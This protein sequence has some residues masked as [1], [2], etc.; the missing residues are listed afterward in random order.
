MAQAEKS[1]LNQFLWNKRLLLVFT[2]NIE[3]PRLG[4]KIEEMRQNTC[5]VQVRANC[6][7]SD[8]WCRPRQRQALFIRSAFF[9]VS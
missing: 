4:A 2:P 3:D 9:E 5:G 7:P 1:D 6:D 8:I